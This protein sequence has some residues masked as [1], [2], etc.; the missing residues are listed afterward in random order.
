MRFSIVLLSFVAAVLA[1]VPPEFQCSRGWRLDFPRGLI[2]VEEAGEAGSCISPPPRM[3]N[4][5]YPRH[6]Q[7][8][9]HVQ[10]TFRA[11]AHKHAHHLHSIPPREKSTRTLIIDHLLWVHART[12][13][14]QAR[15]ELGMTDPSGGPSSSAYSHRR[16]PE[17]YDE[18]E[19]ALSDGEDLS[20]LKSRRRWDN[21]DNDDRNPR[22]DLA[23]AQSLRL[24]AEGLESVINSMLDQPPPH[25][26]VQA[27]I[28]RP[29]S[30]RIVSGTH[31]HTLP[32]GV[33]LR[34]ALGTV[35]ND[36][37]ARQ[38]PP[39][40]YRHTHPPKEPHPH[41]STH[42][43]DL[44]EALIPLVPLSGAFSSSTSPAPPQFDG[45]LSGWQDGSGIGSGLLRPG[46]RGNALRRR[47]Y[48]D[49]NNHNNDRRNPPPGGNT[50]L[51]RLL[52]RFLKLSA[53]VAVELGQEAREDEEEEEEDVADWQKVL[54]NGSKPRP[55]PPPLSSNKG[56]QKD[57]E[58]NKDLLLNNAHQPTR[59]W[60]MLLAGL[61]TR[62]VLEG[63]L[64]AGWRGTRPVECL[65]LVGIQGES[66]GLLGTRGR[67]IGDRGRIERRVSGGAGG[68]GSSDRI[69]NEEDKSEVGGDEEEFRELD[70]DGLPS[71]GHALRVLFPSLR[72][73]GIINESSLRQHFQQ[74]Q[75]QS[76]SQQ[77]QSTSRTRNLGQ[78]E[79][80]YELEMY[81]RLHHFYDIP[82]S[83]PDL[84]THLEDLAW[85]YPAEPVERA[86]VRFCEAVARWRGKPE[87][88]T[89]KKKP[90]IVHVS[91]A[92]PPPVVHRRPHHPPPPPPPHQQ[93]QYSLDSLAEM[94][95]Q[96]Q[97]QHQ[98][99]PLPPPLQP[100]PQLQRQ[101][102][103]S[104]SSSPS[105]PSSLHPLHPSH[106]P[107]PSVGDEPAGQRRQQG[108]RPL[109]DI[110]FSASPSPASNLPSSSSSS[111]SLGYMGVMTRPTMTSSSTVS[112]NSSMG[113]TG[114]MGMNAGMRRGSGGGV[115]RSRGDD[116]GGGGG[117]VKRFHQM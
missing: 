77:R 20:H 16:R 101:G 54:N 21:Y 33:R 34:L 84:S 117:M 9:A 44:P 47:V 96:Q 70:P 42:H 98:S 43:L 107:F 2:R 116:G 93:Q 27:D 35:V 114:M 102:T 91:S 12:R 80:E 90:S 36:L 97:H 17:N 66:G 63:Y 31:P 29:G 67:G 10:P 22:Q 39:Q 1:A 49:A 86:A 106:H 87:L 15:A 11:P 40:P 25:H 26:S 112:A 48:D 82:E 109:I 81:N 50:K 7:S 18:D 55:R 92:S 104:T 99:H 56:K 69:D 103:T 46:I 38:P 115:K 74:Q 37:F 3:R 53:L 5:F 83:T 61:L 95:S 60:Y 113:M 24:R 79:A 19:Q 75:S 110:Y 111:S 45:N 105:L 76:Q 85:S 59:E 41:H 13:F 78:A 100:Q 89:Y 4:S 58:E 94:M 65:L 88:E 64:S 8:P 57:E 62:A 23:L 52:P 32:N 28:D 71:L 51:S 14:A 108:C 72:N 73:N 30:P 68:Q 6:I